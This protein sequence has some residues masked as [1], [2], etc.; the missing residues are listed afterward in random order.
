VRFGFAASWLL[1][2]MLAGPTFAGADVEFDRAADFSKYRTYQW[3]AGTPA[4]D[5]RVQSRITQAVD[6][7]LQAS[8]LQ[9]TESGG[10]LLVVS[11]ISTASDTLAGGDDF[12]YGGWPGWGASSG[13][14]GSP[15]EGSELP[16]GTLIVDLVDAETS[17]LVWRG[18]ASGTVKGT[19]EKTEKS[20]DKKIGKLFRSFPPKDAH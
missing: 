10:D 6:G 17:K 13:M 8:G 11:H 3:K 15:D 12:G 14:G 18:V 19:S 7:R 16:G 4:P 5:K 20:V 2:G 9:R 1:V